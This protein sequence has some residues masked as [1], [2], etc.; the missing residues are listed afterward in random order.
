MSPEN[1][2]M[3]N[4]FLE[5]VSKRSL[6]EAEEGLMLAIL[7]DAIACF[8]KYALARG[9]KGK[10]LFQ[11]A[12]RWIMDESSD[13]IFSFENICEVFGLDPRYVREGLMQWKERSLLR[14]AASRA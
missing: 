1:L 5:R 6:R 14:E 11:E 4:E 7:E 2:E 8:K 3:D 9:G 13:W 12:E 10:A